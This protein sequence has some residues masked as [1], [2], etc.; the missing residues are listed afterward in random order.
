MIFNTLDGTGGFTELVVEGESITLPDSSSVSR[1]GYEL[2]YWCENI[3]GSGTVLNPGSSFSPSKNTTLYA[4]W[5]LKQCEVSFII[6]VNGS[7]SVYR[8]VTVEAGSTIPRPEDPSINVHNSYYYLVDWVDKQGNAWNFSERIYDDMSLY[9][10]AAVLFSTMYSGFTLH[11]NIDQ[12]VRDWTHVISWGDGTVETYTSDPQPDHEYSSARTVTVRVQSTSPDG[13]TYTSYYVEELLSDSTGAIVPASNT[14]GAPVVNYNVFNQNGMEIGDG[15]ILVSGHEIVDA[16]LNGSNLDANTIQRMN[17][18][19]DLSKSRVY[20]EGLWR[21]SVVGY[22][23]V[24]YD[25]D[26]EVYRIQYDSQTYD[27]I[28]ENGRTIEVHVGG[29]INLNFIVENNWNRL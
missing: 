15:F 23:G 25:Y 21:Y 11:L 14:S 2:S 8:T 18:L 6:D 19:R 9:A 27:L 7:H 29:D 10:D 5:E 12:D 4:I 22:N 17:D 16:E 26:I 3:D 24:T 28:S 20:S 1:T 13:D